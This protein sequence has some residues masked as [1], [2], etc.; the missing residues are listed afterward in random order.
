MQA[1]ACWVNRPPISRLALT[2]FFGITSTIHFLLALRSGDKGYPFLQTFSRAPDV[3]L[4]VVIALT[5][6]LHA[7]TAAIT[8]TP[9]TFS[10]L[11]DPGSLPASTDDYSLALFKIGTACLSSTRLSGMDSDLI[12]VN[13]G[14]ETWVEIDGSNVTIKEPGG[15]PALASYDGKG[16]LSREIRKIKASGQAKQRKNSRKALFYYPSPRWTE[17]AIFWTMLY[18]TIKAIILLAMRKVI[19]WLPFTLPSMP[20]WILQIPRRIRLFWHGVNGEARRNAR[21]EEERRRRETQRLRIESDQMFRRRA[22]A[23]YQARAS[24][25]AVSTQLQEGT[26]LRH[27]G[28]SPLNSS[29]LSENATGWQRF[30]SQH[31]EE[32]PEASDEEYR[33]ESEDEGQNHDRSRLTSPALVDQEGDAQGDDTDD[34]MEEIEIEELEDAGDLSAELLSLARVDFEEEVG[35]SSYTNVLMAHLSRQGE[36]VLTRRGYRNILGGQSQ[37]EE[38]AQHLISVVRQRRVQGDLTTPPSEPSSERERMRLCVICYIEDRTIICWPCKC[39]ALCEGCR[40]AMAT[41]PPPRSTSRGT[42]DRSTPPTHVC[43]T[44]RTPVIGY[45]RL[46]LP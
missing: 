33:D 35:P 43:P 21:I 37:A 25:S 15:F 13:T 4:M 10:R 2:S 3:A 38:E 41:R 44:C 46:F 8:D 20:N 29:T 40:E 1:C 32:D 34:E 19:S 26:Q 22:E 42:S 16:G 39:L 12:D 6:F 36:G 28:A 11:I 30:F 45:S 9:L 23:A 14:T 24:S 31:F 5:V 17:A 7:L 18:R 27:R